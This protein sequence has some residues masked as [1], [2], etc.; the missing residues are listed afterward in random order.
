M[1]NWQAT[2]HRELLR[3]SDFREIERAHRFYV[4]LL[5]DLVED[6]KPALW[7]HG[8]TH[9]SCDYQLGVTRVV[10][11][12]Y[13]YGGYRVNKGFRRGLVIEIDEKGDG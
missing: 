6:H 9:L 4:H 13:G 10:C 2:S 1:L 12:P 8:H 3:P 11:N 7:A 5:D